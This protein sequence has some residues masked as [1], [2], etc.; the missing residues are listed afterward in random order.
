VSATRPTVVLLRD[1][2][3][4]LDAAAAAMRVAGW[5]PDG[6]SAQDRR[7]VRGVVVD[8]DTAES[9]VLAVAGGC[10]AVVAASDDLSVW[11]RF[12]RAVEELA[13]TCRWELTTLVGLNATQI[14]LLAVIGNGARVPSAARAASVSERSAHRQLIDARTRLGARTNSH[15]AT[16][17][18][19]GVDRLG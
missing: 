12:V 3:A 2:P 5:E 9:I 19:A 8:S 7:F 1:G 17:V 10:G 6:A 15:A 4:H 13:E 18:R 16:L 14:E 11:C